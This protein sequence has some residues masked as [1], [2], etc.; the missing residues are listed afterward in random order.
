MAEVGDE[1]TG[2]RCSSFLS[3]LSDGYEKIILGIQGKISRVNGGIGAFAARKPVW[4]IVL[5]IL[6]T[7]VASAGWAR[8]RIVSDGDALW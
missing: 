3:R 4:V 6:A 7:A 1:T 2:N 5:G 8:F